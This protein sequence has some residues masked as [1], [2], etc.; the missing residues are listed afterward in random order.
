[1]LFS[2]PQSLIPQQPHENETI[3]AVNTPFAYNF[4]YILFNSS[5]IMHEA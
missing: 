3:S 2:K 5:E 1:M 4:I